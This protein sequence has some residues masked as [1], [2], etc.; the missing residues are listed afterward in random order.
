MIS[1]RLDAFFKISQR[2]STIKQEITAGLTIYLA[3][4]YS[5]IVVPALLHQAGFSLTATFLATCL[6]A[7]FGSLLMGL[8][9]NLP[10]AIG[11][12]ISLTTFT[13]YSIIL[14]QHISIPITLGAIFLMGVTFTLISLTG[15]RSWILRN[16]PRGVA[17]GIGIGIG[18]LLLLIAANSVGLI[19]KN[20][21]QGLPI[22]QGNFASF[23]VIITILGLAAIFG[24]EK[25]RVPGNILL[26]II[27]ISIIGLIFDP[28]VKYHGILALPHI[29]GSKDN[30]LF[31]NMDILGAL[32]PAVLPNIFALVITGVF[33]ATGTIHAV[34]GQ[35]NLLRKDRQIINEA[36]A[37]TSDSVSTIFASCIGAPPAAVYIESATG[38]AV[39][40][41][42]GLTASIVG[43]LFL[44]TLFIAPLSYL[45]PSYATAPALM[46]VGLLMLKNVINLDFTDFIDAISG[47]LCAVFIVLTCNIVTGIMLGFAALVFGRFIAG[48][49]RQLNIGTI[50]IACVLILFYLWK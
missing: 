34:A 1:K 27:A 38:T 29:G 23:P 18:L 10:L 11:C 25:R 48:D 44:F 19:V 21:L 32:K 37:L 7:G 30:S 31:F 36:K 2:N 9:A 50:A 40:G 42:T 45:V 35:A 28:T 39:G 24:L 20:P 6:V 43:L 47:L 12:A 49:W 5:V 13:T 3:M 15:I 46:Y 16:L 17:C 4:L 41:K 33:D 14:T 22:T 8:W 26:V